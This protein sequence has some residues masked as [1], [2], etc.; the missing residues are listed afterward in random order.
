[1]SRA[2][3]KAVATLL[4]KSLCISFTH[5][6]MVHRMGHDLGMRMLPENCPIAPIKGYHVPP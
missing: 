6:I 3:R 2:C 5:I 1:M 4:S